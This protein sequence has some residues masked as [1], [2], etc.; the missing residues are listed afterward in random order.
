[1][2]KIKRYPLNGTFELTA[3]CNLSCEMCYIRIDDKK[4]KELGETEKTFDEWIDMAKQA[5]DAGTMSLL[6]TGG[7]PMLRPDFCEIYKEIAKMGFILTIYTNATMIT[8]KIMDVLKKYPPHTI[9]ITIY[10]ASEETY[11]KVC[12][13]GNAYYK[14][15]HGVEQLLT[16]PSRIELRTT[17]VNNN[18]KDLGK[19]EDFVE[20]LNRDDITLSVSRAVFKSIRGS[21]A[22][23]S[24]CR[25]TPEENAVMFCQRYINT[26][27]KYKHN[28]EN[29]LLLQ[30]K[31]K[32]NK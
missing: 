14:M 26:W 5:K 24:K 21:I 7:E 6:I 10:G 31:I 20:N 19:I 27:N 13:N 11:R 30:S 15:L 28:E 22:Q 12:K 1:M 17:I 4:I 25:L 23:P 18:K 9:G 8:P 16:L 3:R 2:E 32:E 29:R